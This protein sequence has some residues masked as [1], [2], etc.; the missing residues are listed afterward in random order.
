MLSVEHLAVSYNGVPALYDV[1]FRVAPGQI[2]ALVGS[3]GAGKSTTLRAISGLLPPERGLIV[4]NGQRIDRVPAHR[5]ASLGLAHV[6]EG[7]R[8]F[9]RLSVLENLKLG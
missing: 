2:V 3:N 8:L 9:S 1:S 7:R 5:L 4:F 6:P